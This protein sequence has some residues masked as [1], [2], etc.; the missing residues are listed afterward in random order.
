ME[1]IFGFGSRAATSDG[2]RVSLPDALLGLLE[3]SSSHAWECLFTR[4][5]FNM[6]Q[7]SWVLTANDIDGIFSPL[8]DRCRGFHVE[9]P[10]PDDL[11]QFIRYQAKGRIFDEVADLLVERALKATSKGRQ[12]T[13]RRLQ[14]LIDEAV[15]VSKAPVLH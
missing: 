14:Q 4:R 1:G 5:S 7:I 12:P 6:S 11:V 3:P 9:Y 8:L 13:L 2:M 10:A 15:D